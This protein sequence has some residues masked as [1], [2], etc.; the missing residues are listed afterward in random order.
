MGQPFVDM[1]TRGARDSG[2]GPCTDVDCVI[3]DCPTA[4]RRVLYGG[5][6]DD[7][8]TLLAPVTGD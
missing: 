8:L 1:D 6:T 4:G 3:D 5:P 2:L 7:C